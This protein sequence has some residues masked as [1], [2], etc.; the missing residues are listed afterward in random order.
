VRIYGQ[1]HGFWVLDQDEWQGTSM[2]T[3]RKMSSA[4][5]LGNKERDD[6][7]ETKN[8]P[9]RGHWVTD[10]I[11]A[12]VERS[13]S[14]NKST[15]IGAL[16]HRPDCRD[17]ERRRSNKTATSIGGTGSSPRGVETVRDREETRQE[18]QWGQWV[19]DQIVETAVFCPICPMGTYCPSKGGQ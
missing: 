6:D 17:R 5:C 3:A 19:I 2:V 11:V 18:P 14:S 10:P 16:G 1:I 4:V 8:Q 7:R 12:T 15:S 13:R 9:Q